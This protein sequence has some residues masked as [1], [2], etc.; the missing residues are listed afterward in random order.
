M[1]ELDERGWFVCENAVS[2]PLADELAA[3]FD[4]AVGGRAGTRSGLA[5]DAVQ[6]LA[7]SA[8]VRALVEPVLGAGAFA[9]R[10]TLFDKTPIANWLVAWHQDRVIPVAAR[11]DEAGFGPWSVKHG[12]VH[13]QPPVA[14]LHELLAVRVDLDGSGPEGGGL[15]VLSGTHR[16]GVLAPEAIAELV[17]RA[18]AATPAVPKR[19]ALSMRPL[20]L[21]ASSRTKLPRHRRVVHIEFAPRELPGATQ[22]FQRVC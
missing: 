18:P 15:R 4:D 2:V 6:R 11:T 8:A 16:D 9:F 20:L 3:S 14:V 7:R 19:G 5:V 1:R 21:H 22:Y 12:V 17:A 10:A 13:V